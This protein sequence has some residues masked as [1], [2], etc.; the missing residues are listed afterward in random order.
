MSLNAGV[1]VL[2]PS[3]ALNSD[4]PEIIQP[5]APPLVA[6]VVLALAGQVLKVN[7]IL[8]VLA[9]KVAVPSCMR[10]PGAVATTL[11]P[12]SLTGSR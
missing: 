8:V 6:V 1:V 5:M 3:V 7:D 12:T 9:V 4:A 10:L 2:L 11:P